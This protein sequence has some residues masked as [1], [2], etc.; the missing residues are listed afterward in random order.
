MKIKDLKAIKRKI[1]Q[2]AQAEPGFLS[3]FKKDPLSVIHQYTD[4]KLTESDLQRI[5][6]GLM[7]E[8]PSQ[9]GGAL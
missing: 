3:D 7:G 2:R 9:H 5:V 6:G 1:E 4:E 8:S